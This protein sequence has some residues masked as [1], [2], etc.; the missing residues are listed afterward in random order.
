M[1]LLIIVWLDGGAPAAT[2]LFPLAAMLSLVVGLG[3]LGRGIW[4]MGEKPSSSLVW[5]G[6][7]LSLAALLAYGSYML[8]LT[9]DLVWVN[10]LY[11]DEPAA[12]YAT[13]VVLRRILA[14]LPGVVL[15]IL[16]PRVVSRV[17]A[18]ISPDRLLA[19]SALVIGG[20]GGIL[21]AAY[22]LLAAP[23]VQYAAGGAYPQA[24]PLLGR[25]GLAIMGYS[26]AAIW[27]N[28]FLAT[29]PWPFVAILVVGLIAQLI[30]LRLW[31]N[32]LAEVTAVFLVTG[33]LLVAG[34]LAL[35]LLWLRPGLIVRQ[36]E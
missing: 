15:V 21:T 1:A 34:G 22:F 12:T 31:S 36:A 28:L 11:A 9:V 2:A 3:F 17:Q 5:K 29:R 35:Y 24:A 33:W 8:L 25:T 6:W 20:A 16:F 27:L 26:L 7:R 30:A 32:S 14:V 4:Q 19:K 10:R 18:G 13:L 23:I